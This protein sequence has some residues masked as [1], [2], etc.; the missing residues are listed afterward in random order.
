MTSADLLA[1]RRDRVLTAMGAADIDVLVLG[2]QDDANYVSGMHRLWTAGTRPFGAGC[3]VV[4]ATGRTHV[5]SSWDAGLPPTMSPEDLYPMSWNPRMMS[6]HLGAVPG[7]GDARRIGVDEVSPSFARAASRL[8]PEAEVVPADDLMARVRR[9]KTDEELDLIEASCAAAWVGVEAILTD[10]THQPAAG[11]AALG[12]HG[13]TI[14]SSGV[15]VRSLQ[16]ALVVDVGV[17][18]DG[19]EGGVGAVFDPA[20]EPDWIRRPASD[21]VQACRAGATHADFRTAATDTWLVR[22]LGMGFERP[23]FDAEHG[24]EESLEVGMVLSVADGGH[25]EVVAVTTDGPRVLSARPRP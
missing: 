21:L 1:H 19:Y 4:R 16:D 23:V 24:F 12:L 11:I 13:V 22:G 18:V 9:H 25:R 5:L 2:R 6:A 7:L 10:P 20:T 14:P 8:A 17:M 3:I 15:S